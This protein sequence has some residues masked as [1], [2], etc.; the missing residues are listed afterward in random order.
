MLGENWN[1]DLRNSNNNLR[2]SIDNLSSDVKNFNKTLIRN[3]SIKYFKFNLSINENIAK[4]LAK[5]E[6][7]IWCNSKNKNFKN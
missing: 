4:E 2:N 6:Q 3:A 1:K 7:L 5:T